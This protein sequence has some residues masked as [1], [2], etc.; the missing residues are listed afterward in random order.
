MPYNERSKEDPNT[1][2]KKKKK[3]GRSKYFIGNEATPHPRMLAKPSTS[4]TLP[5]GTISNLDKSISTP[6]PLQNKATSI[7]IVQH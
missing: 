6:I 7:G 4:P 3:K 1:K 5:I 2:K